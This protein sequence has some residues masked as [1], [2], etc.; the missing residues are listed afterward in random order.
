MRD[1]TRLSGSDLRE[2]ERTRA[3]AAAYCAAL[4]RRA[5]QRIE[6]PACPRSSLNSLW[7]F[8]ERDSDDDLVSNERDNC[9]L[10]FNPGQRDSD[11]DGLPDVCDPDDDNDGIPDAV[12]LRPQLPDRPAVPA[13]HSPAADARRRPHLPGQPPIWLDAAALRQRAWA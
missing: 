12:D 11:A 2:R 1:V 3:L 10:I 13:D 5:S 8:C 9:P 7:V 4:A 6:S